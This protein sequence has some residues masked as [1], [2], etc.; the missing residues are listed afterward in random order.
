MQKIKQLIYSESFKQLVIYGIIGVIG[1]IIDN[2]SFYLMNKYL[3]TGFAIMPYIYQFISGSLGN[4]NNFICNSFL[5]F[6]VNDHMLKR[7]IEYFLI[8]QLTT[9][10]VWLM[11]LIFHTGLHINAMP[12][13]LIATLVAT[14]L[15]FVINKRITFKKV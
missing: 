15:Q 8:G 14:L 4:I 7:F 5:N 13:K 9:V 10:F 11:L 6:K 3:L 1:L 2:G 12:V